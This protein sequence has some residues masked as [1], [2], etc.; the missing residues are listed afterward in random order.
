LLE[1]AADICG[2]IQEVLAT[3]SRKDVPFEFL[4]RYIGRHLLDLFQDI[5]PDEPAET[6][7]ALI[8]KY[9]AIYP[10]REHRLTKPYPVLRKRWRRLAAAR[11]R[12]PPRDAYHAGGTGE[13]RT[14]R[15]F[16][17]RARYGRLPA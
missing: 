6:C 2:A 14:H 8:Q 5:F 4:R 11:P 13:I 16:R 17:P 7:D 3:T 10:T 15:V 9:R 12:S 1:S